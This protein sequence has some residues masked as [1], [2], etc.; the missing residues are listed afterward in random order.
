M[1]SWV[2]IVRVPLRCNSRLGASASLPSNPFRIRTSKKRACNPCRINTSKRP[3]I[4]IKTNDFNPIRIRTYK[5]ARLAQKTKDFKSTRINTYA[6]SHRN[7]LESALTKK[8]G[9]RGVTSGLAV[10]SLAAPSAPVLA[11]NASGV[12]SVHARQRYPRGHRR[13]FVTSLLH[14][15]VPSPLHSRP[16]HPRS[17]PQGHLD[18]RRFHQA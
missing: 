14:C 2:V 7:P 17:L 5:T 15:V 12:P 10:F 16:H 6:I 4:C 3:R 8:V 1:L 13:S 9:G 11:F 18:T